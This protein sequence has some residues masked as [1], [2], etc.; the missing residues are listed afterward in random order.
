MA[1]VDNLDATV[2]TEDSDSV[3]IGSADGIGYAGGEVSGADDCSGWEEGAPGRVLVISV[4]YDG[5]P[6]LCPSSS[7]PLLARDI[8][9]KELDVEAAKVDEE[10]E[11]I[12]ETVTRTLEVDG[13]AGIAKDSA[14]L[15]SGLM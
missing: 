6:G 11:V 8:I 5:R 12:G 2:V 1:S 4:E 15:G 14:T 13:A 3:A 7:G 10:E 9:I